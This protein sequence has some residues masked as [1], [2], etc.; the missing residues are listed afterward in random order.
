MLRDEANFLLNTVP[1]LQPGSNFN[2]RVILV[3]FSDGWIDIYTRGRLLLPES[4]TV[5]VIKERSNP[6]CQKS[7]LF[8]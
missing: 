1:V 4:K 8:N 7:C 5:K 6:D 3:A 2:I